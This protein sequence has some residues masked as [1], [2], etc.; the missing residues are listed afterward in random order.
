M[1]LRNQILLWLMLVGLLPLLL[2]LVASII[3]GERFYQGRV[4][5]ELTTELNRISTLLDDRLREHNRVLES[6]VLSP[7]LEKFARSLAD[8][9]ENQYLTRTFTE[10]KNELENYL[11]DLQPLIPGDAVIRI[12]DQSG[13]TLIKIRFGIATQLSLESLPP[14]RVLEQDPDDMLAVNLAFLPLDSISHLRFPGSSNDFNPGSGLALLDAVLPVQSEKHR[15]YIIYSSLGQ[16]LDHALDL[17]P[18]LRESELIILETRTETSSR[19]LVDDAI[20]QRFTSASPALTISPV[21][22]ELVASAKDTPEG[23]MIS[24]LDDNRYV[25]TEYHPY[26]DRLLNWIIA[27]R[28]SPTQLTSDLQLLRKGLIGLT[29]FTLLLSLILSGWV[30]RYLSRPIY[31]LA[32]NIKAYAKGEPQVPTVPSHIVEVNEV[33]QAFADMAGTLHNT[34]QQLLLSAKM[35]SIGEMAAGIGHELNNPLNNMSSLITLLNRNQSLDQQAKSDTTALMEEV[36]RASNIVRGILNFARQMPPQYE[37]IDVQTWLHEC[38]Q[39]VTGWAAEKQLDI[40]IQVDGQINIEA[41]P[42][43]L[44]Q[45][46]VNLL[47][48]AID[49]SEQ[50]AEISVTARQ[51]GEYLIILVEDYGTGVDEDVAVRLFEP[52]FTTKPVGEGSGLGLSISLGIIESHGGQ[53]TL[54]NNDSGGLTAKI[55]LP[56]NHA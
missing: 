29:L 34:E 24:K 10:D 19:L 32:D 5:R 25:F 41:D 27:A 56:L 12:V 23:V 54:N 36:K 39:R 1:K 15:M 2:L 11:L 50:H 40:Q 49:A 14:Y 46:V 52:F 38:V 9:L 28:I 44:E 48:N 13:R 21:H 20:N 51:Q 18:R 42:A 37:S 6:V 53:L 35:A 7:T 16:Q 26:A 22:Q 3:Y 45:V 17:A 31:R 43:Q 55:S 33:Q 47:N 30:A 8:V 4:D